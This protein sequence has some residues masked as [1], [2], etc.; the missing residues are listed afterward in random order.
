MFKPHFGQ[1]IRSNALTRHGLMLKGPLP[2]AES[3]EHFRVPAGVLRCSLIIQQR[4]DKMPGRSPFH[5]SMNKHR[6]Q[7]WPSLR[8][9][10]NPI[11]TSAHIAAAT[12]EAVAFSK[13]PAEPQAYV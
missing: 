9:P 8:M 7:E 3:G 12:V 4:R 10:A 11:C 6:H 5:E 13:T 2:A 1:L